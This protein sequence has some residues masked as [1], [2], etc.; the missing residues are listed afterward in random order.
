MPGIPE[1]FDHDD[2]GD[3]FTIFCH[4]RPTGHFDGLQT[5]STNEDP[6]HNS[7][8]LPFQKVDHNAGCAH[9]GYRRA[10]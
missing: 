2:D 5:A 6:P 1:D 8:G 9:F 7:V 10:K 4:G 3:D